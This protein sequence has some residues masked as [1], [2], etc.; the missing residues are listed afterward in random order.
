MP[1]TF[2][3][4]SASG[5]DRRAFLKGTAMAAGAGLLAAA[6]AAGDPRPLADAE[7]VTRIAS[8]TYPIR[9]LFKRRPSTSQ[10]PPAVGAVSVD[11]MKKKYGEITLL[12]F[13]QFTIDTFPGVRKMDLWS[14]LFGDVADDSMFVKVTSTRDGRT[15]E[16]WEF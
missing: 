1:T 15:T 3:P 14:S 8:N 2:P 16:A 6:P 4:A 12:D 5:A 10:P 9:S 11:A 7:K 13:P